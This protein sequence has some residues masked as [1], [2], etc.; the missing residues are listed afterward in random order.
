[1]VMVGVDDNL[2]DWQKPAA[3]KGYEALSGIGTEAFTVDGGAYGW[4][5]AALTDKSLVFVSV[6]GSS[7]DRDAAIRLL[8]ILV[9]RL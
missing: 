1:M 7:S 4:Q 2:E 8:R 5:A 6:L 3:E 9:E